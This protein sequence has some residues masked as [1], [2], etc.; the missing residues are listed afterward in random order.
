MGLREIGS[1]AFY[2]DYTLKEAIL[3]DSMETIKQQAFQYCHHLQ[4]VNLGEGLQTLGIAAFASCF[5]LKEITIPASITVIP[6]SAFMY[7]YQLKRVTLPDEIITIGSNAFMDCVCLNT[8]HLPASLEIID[9]NAFEECFSLREIQMPAS[10]QEIKQGAFAN[11]SSRLTFI[12]KKGS[13]VGQYAEGTFAV[14]YTDTGETIP[15]P[16][17]VR[18]DIFCIIQFLAN[19]VFYQFPGILISKLVRMITP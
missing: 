3:P 14:R 13:Y 15:M 4:T 12:T 2:S 8:D 16:N 6:D 10:L 1:L 9:W 18:H 11:C 17:A 19:T 7:C 5:R